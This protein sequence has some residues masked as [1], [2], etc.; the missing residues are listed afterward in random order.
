VVGRVGLRA[1]LDVEAGCE[2]AVAGA[3][4]QNGPDGGVVGEPLE[5]GGEVEPH[6]VRGG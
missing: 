5:D 3:G 2:G 6:A 4:E 1:Y